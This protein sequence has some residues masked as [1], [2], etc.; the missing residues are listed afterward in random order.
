MCAENE[1]SVATEYSEEVTGGSSENTVLTTATG[2]C[3]LTNRAVAPQAL[4][5]SRVTENLHE[6]PSDLIQRLRGD[7]A[8]MNDQIIALLPRLLC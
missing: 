5:S 4:Q 7:S 8:E 6:R 3:S 1:L 2:D